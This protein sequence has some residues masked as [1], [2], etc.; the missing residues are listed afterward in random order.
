MRQFIINIPDAQYSFFRK[1][2]QQLPWVQVEQ[3]RRVA[4]PTTAAAPSAAEQAWGDEVADA[5]RD[6]K[7]AERGEIKLQDAREFLRQ[8]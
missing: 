5:L 2:L 1:L 3:T 7:R 4:S 8:L 6:A